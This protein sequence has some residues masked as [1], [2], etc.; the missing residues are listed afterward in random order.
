MPVPGPPTGISPTRTARYGLRSLRLYLRRS[1]LELRRRE[2][3]YGYDTRFTYSPLATVSTENLRG[4][5]KNNRLLFQKLGL[6]LSYCAYRNTTKPLSGTQS[7]SGHRQEPR[8]YARHMVFMVICRIPDQCT[9][10]CR[11]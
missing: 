11:H 6:V 7:D 8:I 5:W 9:V 4:G 2:T 10:Y 3:L 1:C